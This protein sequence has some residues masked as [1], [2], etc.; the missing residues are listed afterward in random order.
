[1]LINSD[2]W[3][4]L[5][6]F[7]KRGVTERPSTKLSMPKLVGAEGESD[8]N[9]AYA[10][11]KFS[12]PE[13]FAIDNLLD[14]EWKK[15]IVEYLENPSGTVSRKTRYRSLSYVIIGNELFKKTVEG[16]LLKCINEN[17]VYLAV[18]GVHS[19]AF[20]SH[21]AGHKMKWLIF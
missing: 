19:G 9:E 18:S 7:G 11:P 5:Y 13:I 16:I 17:E 8:S 1:L 6:H 12:Y 4:L 20:G 10:Y 3:I 21:Q 15:P 2:V 14:N